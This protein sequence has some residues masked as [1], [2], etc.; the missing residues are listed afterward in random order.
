[1][2]EALN[3]ES[4]EHPLVVLTFALRESKEAGADGCCFVLAFLA[5][6]SASI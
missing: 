5:G 4:A 6:H 3:G 1:M 2:Q